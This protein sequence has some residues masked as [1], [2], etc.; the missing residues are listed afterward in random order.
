MAKEPTKTV[1]MT[2]LGV[3]GGYSPNGYLKQEEFIPALRGNKAIKKYREM[4]ENDPIIGATLTAM[5]MLIRAVEWKFEGTEEAV[6]FIESVFDDMEGTMEDFLSEVLSF[7]PY[8]FSFFEVVYKRRM[9]RRP[10]T[11]TNYS[12]FD[13][14]MIGIRKLAPRAQW[15]IERFDVTL[16]GDILGAYQNASYASGITYIPISKALLFRTT[17][18]NNDPSGRSVLRNA[19]LPYY[20]S[21]NLQTIE[22]IAIEREMNGMPIGKV[23]SEYLKPDAD[24]A[25]KQFVAEFSRILRDA[26]TN[27]QSF[28]MLPS[29]VYTNENGSLSAV[30]KVSFE[31]IASRGTRAIDI[32]KVIRRHQANIART[33]LADFIMLGQSDRG[34]FALSQSKTDLFLRSIEGFVDNIAAVLNKD[35]IPKIWAINGLNMATIPK[36]KRGRVAPVNLEELGRFVARLAGANEN[37]FTDETIIG[38]L[39]DKA[40]IAIPEGMP[41]LLSPRTRERPTERDNNGNIGDPISQQGTED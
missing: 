40:D 9:G 18:M 29:D 13:D 1:A 27:E 38:D 10:N 34:S 30:P 3:A 28:V 37:L 24:P 41:D 8:G 32:D 14:G 17:S 35:L 11:P 25:K 7:L 39:L 21:T 19:Y 33:V 22:A 23:P 6:Q 16:N 4:R 12:K 2:E 5:D 15:T 20:Y 26:R 31:L 36:I